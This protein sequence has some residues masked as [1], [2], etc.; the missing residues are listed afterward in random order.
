MN[1]YISLEGE[2]Y[3]YSKKTLALVFVAILI[4]GSAFY[5]GAKTEKSKLM[6]LGLLHAEACPTVA[7]TKT[8]KK[9]A[10]KNALAPT[11]PVVEIV[12]GSIL[13]KDANSITIKTADNASLVVT[14]SPATT[15]GKT[16]TDKVTA[17]Y[18]KESVTVSG[19][20][21]ADGTLLAPNIQPLI[22]VK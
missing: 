18:L 21:N 11:A 3:G 6:R 8:S 20:K 15:F 7:S 22:V 2:I 9:Q 1:K 13:T 5:A 14:L 12:S 17:L 19:T 10:K 4:A 16:N